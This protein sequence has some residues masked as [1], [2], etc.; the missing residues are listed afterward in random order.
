MYSLTDRSTKFAEL[1]RT[2]RARQEAQRA[3]SGCP[4]GPWAGWAA[5]GP[6]QADSSHHPPFSPDFATH[7]AHLVLRVQSVGNEHLA[8]IP[9]L[10]ITIA[11]ADD[12]VFSAI[13][14]Y[15]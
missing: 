4:K 5:Q 11:I 6:R 14:S 3:E 8:S 12:A 13:S 10:I 2:K 7:L 15:S 1:E 9:M